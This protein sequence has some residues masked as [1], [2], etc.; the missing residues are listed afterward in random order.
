MSEDLMLKCLICFILGWFVCRMMGNG[1]SVGGT[2]IPQK[3]FDFMENQCGNIKH[4]SDLYSTDCSNCLKDIDQIPDECNQFGSVDD[5]FKAY[6]YEQPLI[7]CG[8][9]LTCADNPAAAA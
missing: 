4:K 8:G 1:F 7:T 3:C 6:C 5:Y 2:K 9:P